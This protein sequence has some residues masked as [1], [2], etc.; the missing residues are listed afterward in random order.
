LLFVVASM[1]PELAG[2]QREL[3]AAESPR[4]VG[5]P[6]EFHFVGVGP[7][8]AGSA[9]AEALSRT[10]RKP[11]GVL[12]LGVAGAVDPGMESGD[13]ILADTYA[14]DTKEDT[15]ADIS[16]DPGMLEVAEA[17]AA[18]LRM[19]VSR[20]SSLTVDHLIVEGQERRELR[21]KY[22]VG[23]VNMEDHAVASAASRAGIPFLSVR[24]VLDT[25][26][27]S[28]PGYL[29][30]LSKGRGAV[31]TEIMLKPWRIPTLMRLKSQ[32][33]LCQSVITRFGMT[34]FKMESER[35]RQVRDQQAKEAI[36]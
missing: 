32:M 4:G 29:P 35:R 8:R 11:E 9:M 18:D 15:S 20:A 21:E 13:V 17:A 6:V 34:Y 19:P 2:L 5:I 26:E 27:Q 23:S 16:P 30:G 31:F 7:R 10:K 28:I 14:L 3:E 12:M 1:E 22:K 25:A 33:D 24:T 36:Y